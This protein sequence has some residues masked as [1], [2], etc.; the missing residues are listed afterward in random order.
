MVA[1][2]PQMRRFAAAGCLLLSGANATAP[3]PEPLRLHLD[4][5]RRTNAVY[6]VACLARSISCSNQIFE[7][8]WHGRL[9]WMPT[10]QAALDKWRQVMADVT[11]R[12]PPRSGAPLLPNTPRFHPAQA[13]RTVVFVAAVES[14]SARDLHRRSRGILSEQAAARLHAALDHFERRLEPWWRSES[15]RRR[16]IDNRLEAV[17]ERTRQTGMPQLMAEVAAFL[18]A[19]LADPVLYLHAILAPEPASKDYTATQSGSHFFVEAVDAATTEAFVHGAAHELTHYLYDNARE[20]KQIGLIREFT[21][22]EATGFAGLYTYLNEALAIA[23]QALYADRLG[24]RG[25]EAEAYKHPYIHPLGAVATPLLKEAIAGRQ[26]LF[27]SFAARYIAAGTAALGDKLLEPQFALAQVALLL[28]PDAQHLA[29]AYFERMFPQ[30]SAQFRTQVDVDAFPDL[31]VVRFV[32][33]DELETLAGRIPDLVSL[34][35]RKGFAYA[36]K[37]GARAHTYVLAGRD[38]DAIV[39]VVSR[40]AALERLG[41]P[42]LLFSL[43]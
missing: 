18:E 24:E 21:Q 22:S 41:T 38:S 5:S 36:M 4:A 1:S 31:N 37:R 6:H 2:T 20:E 34:R 40:F 28:P 27:S 14:R 13:S 23:A 19:E 11:D 42:G 8:L 26:T 35:A 33:Y 16:A 43:D 25:S 12:A 9:R 15:Q 39:D 32:P 10:D 3:S 30:A 29:A 7:R 17:A